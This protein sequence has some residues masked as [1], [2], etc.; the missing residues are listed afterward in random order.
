[1]RDA[2]GGVFMFNLLIVF[3]FIFVAFSAVSLTYAK[4]FRLK[5]S[6]ISYVEEQEIISLD[7][8]SEK[9][10][11]IDKILQ[12][13]SYYKTCDS[14]GYNDGKI[15]SAEGKTVGYCH[16]GVVIRIKDGYPQ[17][18]DGTKNEENKTITK[19]IIYEITTYADWN[20]GVLNK[21]L[22]LG[23]Q[24]EDSQSPIN[25]FWE[26]KGEAKVVARD[27]KYN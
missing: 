12:G 18:V 8:N 27:V 9:L 14:I 6:L 4:A 11:G 23:G 26:I 22:A 17:N 16:N 19:L 2:F 10:E 13:A 21:I 25:G 20:L 24:S 1:M 7:L 15:K 3:I 5:N